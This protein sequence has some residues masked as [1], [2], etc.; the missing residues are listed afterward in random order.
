MN[1]PGPRRR[2]NVNGRRNTR[3]PPRRARPGPRP[4]ARPPVRRRRNRRRGVRRQR[5][6]GMTGQ[7][8][9]ETFVFT[10]DDLKGNSSGSITFG[11]S[12]TNCV[13]L[14]GGILKA[15]HEYK[16]TMVTLDYVSEASSTSA[17]SISY[18]ID[19]HCK[20]TELKSTLNKFGI[21]KNG[22]RNLPSK[23]INGL[24]W[25]E[26]SEDQFRILYKGNGATTVAGS[27]R[28]TIRVATQNP[29]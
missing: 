8:R 16:I 7:N 3:P 25:H 19:A 1:N 13:A 11:P 17:G 10:V 9:G 15:Y 14:S 22:K 6:V 21:T 12:L 26:T 28:I 2:N 18:E 5:A 23:L 4:A 20:L 27:F 24:E 29:K